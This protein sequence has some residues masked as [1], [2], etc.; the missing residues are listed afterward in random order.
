MNNKILWNN[1]KEKINRKKKVNKLKKI[2]T[3]KNKK[4][5]LN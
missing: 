1:N 4:W 5:K 2:K 3:D